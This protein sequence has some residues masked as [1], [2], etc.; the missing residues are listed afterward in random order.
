MRLRQAAWHYWETIA[1]NAGRLANVITVV[2][3]LTTLGAT[4][5]AGHQ[6]LPLLAVVL[7]ASVGTIV[8]L[9]I[10]VLIMALSLRKSR[11]Y[12]RTLN[13]LFKESFVVLDSM[14]VAHCRGS[15]SQNEERLSSCL[16]L[17]LLFARNHIAPG[18]EKVISYLAYDVAN[19][20]FRRVARCPS[21]STGQSSTVSRMNMGNSLAGRALKEGK[22]QHYGDVTSRSAKEGGFDNTLGRQRIGSTI[23]APVLATDDRPLGVLGC[24]C[25]DSHAFSTGDVELLQLLASKVCLTYAMFGEPSG[26]TEAKVTAS[27]SGVGD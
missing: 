13:G 25:D 26:S 23:Q 21:Q 1:D 27:G 12:S 22:V 5:L 19:D 17:L 10:V 6:P 4:L 7:V 18:R 2:G 16:D 15:L 14:L 24:D 20:G 9:L 11:A 3:L 8:T